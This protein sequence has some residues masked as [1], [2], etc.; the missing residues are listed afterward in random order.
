MILL[1]TGSVRG[2]EDT[3]GDDAWPTAG[4][5]TSQVQ[6]QD[7]AEHQG[8]DA[9]PFGLGE[10]IQRID[11]AKLGNEDSSEVEGFNDPEPTQEFADQGMA[12]PDPGFQPVGQP[13]SGEFLAEEPVVVV[14]TERLPLNEDAAGHDGLSFISSP[15]LTLG[16]ILG[17][18]ES[19]GG[20]RDKRFPIGTVMKSNALGRNLQMFGKALAEQASAS[21]KSIT[22]DGKSKLV[23]ATA[24]VQGER[25]P[26]FLERYR[27]VRSNIGNGHADLIGRHA[28]EIV[29]P[30]LSG[31]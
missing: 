3:G 22:M 23:R 17:E 5:V 24:F 25:G 7:T 21:D 16:V 2:E 4:D 20:S 1:G 19:D 15:K 12:D 13:E 8:T 27:T 26:R 18:V 29:P 6:V 28:G 9:V 30:H 31:K 11:Q 14:P 10:E